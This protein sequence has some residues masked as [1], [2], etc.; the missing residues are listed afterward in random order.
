MN[1]VSNKLGNEWGNKWDGVSNEWG[2]KVMNGE[3]RGS[4]Y[5]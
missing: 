4:I 2:K 3:M 5:L 1:G